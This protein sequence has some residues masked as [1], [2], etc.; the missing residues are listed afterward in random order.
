LGRRRK[1]EKSLKSLQRGTKSTVRE[2]GGNLVR[3]N[4]GKGMRSRRKSKQK[5]EGKKKTKGK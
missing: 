2:G 5:A 4:K 3:K 1:E